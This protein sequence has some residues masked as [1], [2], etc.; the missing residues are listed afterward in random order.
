M[1][2]CSKPTVNP[3]SRRQVRVQCNWVCSSSLDS[4]ISGHTQYTGDG[5]RACALAIRC[6]A[7]T[8]S[9]VTTASDR[10]FIDDRDIRIG[11]AL[12][13]RPRYRRRVIINWCVADALWR[14]ASRWA[15][16]KRCCSSMIANPDCVTP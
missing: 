8:R 6:G 9:F 5:Q 11:V 10:H 12:S 2:P 4:S 16:P 14:S 13:K 15:T 3:G 7:A 1:R